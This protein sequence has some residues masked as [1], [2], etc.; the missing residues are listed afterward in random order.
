MCPTM[1]NDRFGD[2]TCAA[3]LHLEDESH[4]VGTTLFGR[5]CQQKAAHRRKQCQL[6][7]NLSLFRTL[8]LFEGR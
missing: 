4:R 3:A 8:L 6:R 1:Q 7:Y 5:K 2:Q